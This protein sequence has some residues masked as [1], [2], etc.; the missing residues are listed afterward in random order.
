MTIQHP[1]TSG[2]DEDVRAQVQADRLAALARLRKAQKR[3]HVL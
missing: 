2:E 1:D 3:G